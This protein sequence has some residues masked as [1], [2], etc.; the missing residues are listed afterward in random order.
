MKW[1]E[2]GGLGR[3]QVVLVWIRVSGVVLGRFKVSVGGFG[4]S[5]GGYSGVVL[6]KRVRFQG[7]LT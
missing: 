6:A 2:A 3:L 4:V 7:G 5:D 1:L